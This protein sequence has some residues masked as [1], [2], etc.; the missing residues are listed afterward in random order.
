MEYSTPASLSSTI[1]WSLLKFMSIELVMLSNRLILCRSLLLLPS[2]FPST[3]VFSNES[4]L[5]TRWPK[6]WSFSVTIS[7]S[8]EYSGLIYFRID[9][10]DLP[11]VQ[12]TLKSLLQHHNSKASIFDTSVKAPWRAKS[13]K[14]LLEIEAGNPLLIYFKFVKYYVLLLA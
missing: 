9:W 2:I 13:E 7:P 12:E 8:N 14:P 1:S 6:Y 11:A 10:F 3:R 4:V 5:L